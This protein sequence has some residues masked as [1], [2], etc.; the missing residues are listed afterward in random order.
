MIKQMLAVWVLL[1]AMP[2]GAVI[3]AYEFD[4]DV[5]RQRYLSFIEEMRCPKCQNQNLAGSDS[6][7]AADLRRELYRMLQEGKADKEIVDFMVARY[8]DYVLYRPQV[9]SDTWLLWGLP[10]GLLFFGVA[11]VVVTLRQR[12]S[13]GASAQ[14]SGMKG[15]ESKSQRRL[16]ELL[17]QAKQ[18][19]NI[20]G[21]RD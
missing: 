19:K 12:R 14:A 4:N 6:P 2:S 8:G 15:E 18:R 13:V 5:T 16:E 11:M 17:E 10:A 20:S 3:D 1:F 21:G 7:I 9:K